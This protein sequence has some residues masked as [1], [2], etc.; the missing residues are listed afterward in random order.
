[1]VDGG[2]QNI[3]FTIHRPP[4]TD[5]LEAAFNQMTASADVKKWLNDL[6]S[7]VFPGNSK[8]LADLLAADTKKW[9][10]Y[11]KLAKIEPQ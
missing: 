1:M 8:M 2:W 11:V 10:E 6:G 7:D 4:I 5:R 9:A 3:F